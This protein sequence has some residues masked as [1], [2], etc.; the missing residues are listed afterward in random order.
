MKRTKNMVI[1][2]T[3][4]SRDLF[5]YATNEGTLYP[6]TCE[7][8]RC[9]AKKWAKGTYDADKAIDAYFPIATEA[10][11]RYCKEFGSRGANPFDMFDVTARFTA[12][13]EMEAY[14]REDVEADDL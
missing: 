7:V 2:A 13:A 8:V 9:L 5:L 10:A 1:K 4:E 14:Y 12:A 6:W 11:K 3:D